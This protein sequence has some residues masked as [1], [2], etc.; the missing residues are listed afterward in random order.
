MGF[1]KLEDIRNTVLD[2][3]HLTNWQQ[4]ESRKYVFALGDPTTP[5]MDMYRGS[6][7]ALPARSGR[8]AD[9]AQHLHYGAIKHN[10]EDSRAANYITTSSGS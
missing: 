7:T 9:P 8:S 2:N 5:T 1:A 6:Y 3:T 4:S 10:F